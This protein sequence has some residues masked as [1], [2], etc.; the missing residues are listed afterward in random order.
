MIEK[1][2]VAALLPE[3]HNLFVQ[4]E[5]VQDGEELAAAEL[6]TPS[7][8]DLAAAA[9]A[10]ADAEAA[11]GLAHKAATKKAEEARAA[12]AAAAAAGEAAESAARAH[13]RA[14]CAL[15]VHQAEREHVLALRECA[16]AD[17]ELRVKR[18]KLQSFDA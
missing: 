6:P 13:C 16:A 9:R 8:E 10:V 11:V 5:L 7:E 1:L 18:R 2:H 15:E 12:A 3:L 4:S 14:L 17:E